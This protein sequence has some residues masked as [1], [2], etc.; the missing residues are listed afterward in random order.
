MNKARDLKR[1]EWSAIVWPQSPGRYRSG[2]TGE[3]VN[4]LAHA[5]EGSN[6][7]RPTTKSLNFGHLVVVGSVPSSPYFSKYASSGTHRLLELP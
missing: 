7:S 6:P 3:T 4:L 2:Q 5:F 1:S